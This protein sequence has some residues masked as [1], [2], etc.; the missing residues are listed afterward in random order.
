[1]ELI[2]AL[3]MV[4]GIAGLRAQNTGPSSKICCQ[5]FPSKEMADKDA[6]RLAVVEHICL[7][8]VQIDRYR[9][10]IRSKMVCRERRSTAS[11]T[12]FL[13]SLR[14]LSAA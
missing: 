3:T 12:T 2:L 8:D 7:R 6:A 9:P 5:Q 4:A 1:M 11:S 10:K 13:V 14:L